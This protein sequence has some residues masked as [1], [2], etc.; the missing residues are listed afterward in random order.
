MSKK[1][2]VSRDDDGW[3]KIWPAKPRWEDGSFFS[4]EDSK[5]YL[6]KTKTSEFFFPQLKIKPGQLV[7]VNRRLVAINNVL[8]KVAVFTLGKII[9]DHGKK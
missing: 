7:E 9:E 4:W 1:L 3:Y 2:Y 5:M 8:P 6:D